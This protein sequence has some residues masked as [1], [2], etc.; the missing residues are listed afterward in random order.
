M[1]TS[2]S[3]GGSVLTFISGWKLSE[4]NLSVSHRGLETRVW[5]SRLSGKPA[6]ILSCLTNVGSK[7]FPHC[8]I[9]MQEFFPPSHW[10]KSKIDSCSILEKHY[11]A[12]GDVS[13]GGVFCISIFLY[14]NPPL[15]QLLSV[16]SFYWGHLSVSVNLI[17]IGV[18]IGKSGF[19]L[20]WWWFHWHPQS[21][22]LVSSPHSPAPCVRDTP[23]ESFGNFC[24]WHVIPCPR[25]MFGCW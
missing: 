14:R 8:Y 10:R 6:L 2:G 23:A 15:S 3:D 25:G 12:D 24:M 4:L 5:V 7:N 9:K 21:P 11:M 22:S 17:F 13:S 19:T 16:T 1:E 18:W 20:N